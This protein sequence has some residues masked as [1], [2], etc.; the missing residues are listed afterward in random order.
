MNSTNTGQNS[1]I[2]KTLGLDS[3]SGHRKNLKRWF[4]WGVPVLV[5]ILL[6]IKWTMSNGATEVRYKTQPVTRGNITITVTATGN[7]APTNQVEVGSELSGIVDTVDADYNDHVAVGQVLAKLDTSR[8]DAEVLQARAT[9]ASARAKVLQT[10]ATVSESRSQLNRLQEVRKL[11]NAKAVSQQDVDAAQ[12]LLDRAVADEASANAVVDQAKAALEAILTDLSKTVIHSPINGIVLVRSVEP[13]QTVA[14]SL[15]APVLF[16][17]A[18]DLTKMELHVDV[19]EADVA[20][21][22]EGQ[23]ATF[24]VDAYPDRTF[25]AKITQVRFGSKTVDGGVTYE[26]VLNVDNSDLSLRPGRTPTADITVNKIENGILVPN[27]VLRFKPPEIQ[28]SSDSTRR[29]FMMLFPSRPHPAKQRTELNPDINHQLVWTQK[30]GKLES[31]AVVTG[32]SDGVMTEIKS[33]DIT[34]GMELVVDIAKAGS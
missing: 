27:A 6:L 23:D 13:G 9:L 28:E 7:L 24:T 5:V 26:A 4:Y 15:Q 20:Q 25:P 29:G 18:E 30:K 19:D 16:T 14:A 22:K 31:I 21:V 11:S 33:D 34:P 10:K 32:E 17:L 2:T 1:E 3:T 12:A 8:L